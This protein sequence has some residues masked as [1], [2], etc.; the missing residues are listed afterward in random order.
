MKY[1]PA[2]LMLMVWAGCIAAFYLLPFRLEGRIMTL[3]GF[4]ILFLFIAAFCAGALAAAR[5]HPQRPRIPDIAIDFRLTD[6]IL[7]AAGVIAV[8]ASLIDVQGRNVL[9]LAD[10]YQLRSDRASALMLGGS[11]DSTIWFQFAFLTYPAGYIYLV[12]EIAYQRRPALWRI[13][14]F[15]LAPVVLA[16]LAMGGRAPLFYAMV[17][18]VYGFALRKQLFKPRAQ[19]AAR[20]G[21][22]VPGKP[23]R[24]PFKLGG[25][26]KL[27]LGLFGAVGFL[28]F[29]QVFFARADV[30]GGVEVMFG[31]AQMSWGVNFNGAFSGV[32]FTL[33]GAEGTYLIFIFVW[34]LVQ[35]LV[36]SNAIFSDYQGAMLF[37]G[38]GIDLMSALMRRLNGEFLAGAYAELLDLNVYGF[39]P[40]AFGSLFV[41]LKFFG[42]LP[43][44][45]WGWLTGKVYAKVREGRDPRWLMMV[46]FIT[47]G[48]FFSLINTPIGFSNGL[49][50]HIWMIA[51]FVTSKVVTRPVAARTAPARQAV[52]AGR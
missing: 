32:F 6:R 2:V 44:L 47:V 31:V 1:H 3:Y 51:A 23:V 7:M 19:P 26:A 49:V 27:A 22:R 12:R 42:L 9:D 36:M 43:C 13:G 21:R 5:P 30:V 28:Y 25:P 34:Y 39:L 33:F 4:M 17:M 38:Y 37:G 10:A 40:S 15:G 46:P 52:M 48:I 11:S 29:I 18:L 14:A 50:T 45:L 35:G 16:S 8:L 41:D 20:P 24:K